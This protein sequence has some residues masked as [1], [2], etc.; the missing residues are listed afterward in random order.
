MFILTQFSQC[1][2]IKLACS[3]HNVSYVLP[4]VWSAKIKA[5]MAAGVWKS[6]ATAALTA[7]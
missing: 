7:T 1:F 2:K 5:I 6:Q 4:Y 3:L